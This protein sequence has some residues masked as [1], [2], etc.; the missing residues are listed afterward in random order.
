MTFD[1]K[2][3]FY[4]TY[5]DLEKVQEFINSGGS[6][7]ATY[8]N[9]PSLTLLQHAENV[10]NSGKREG[11][12]YIDYKYKYNRYFDNYT[13]WR[14]YNFDDSVIKYLKENGAVSIKFNTTNLTFEDNQKIIELLNKK[15]DIKI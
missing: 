6:V 9:D 8:K 2:L 11:D 5:M 14:P 10:Y 13:S 1:D 7:N 15:M 4:I 3:K 12:K